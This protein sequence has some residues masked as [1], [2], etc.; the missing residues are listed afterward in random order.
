M[1]T[2]CDANDSIKFPLIL[3]LYLLRTEVEHYLWIAACQNKIIIN[4]NAS[5]ILYR[6]IDILTISLENYFSIAAMAFGV[7]SL[8]T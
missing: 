5:I 6:S 8:S 4:Q 3:L 1:K 2:Q 7:G